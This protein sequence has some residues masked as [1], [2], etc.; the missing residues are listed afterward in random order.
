MRSVRSIASVA[1]PSI[2]AIGRAIIAAG[3]LS[4]MPATATEP[5]GFVHTIREKLNVE[6]P[7][8]VV[9]ELTASNAWD[10]LIAAISS[11]YIS[12]ISLVPEA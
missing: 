12:A 2:R 8:K 4:A 3:L 5:L 11:G 1:R 7:A 6:A 9:A 10:T